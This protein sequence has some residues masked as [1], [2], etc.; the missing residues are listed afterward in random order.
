MATKVNRDYWS[1]TIYNMNGFPNADDVGYLDGQL[2]DLINNDT[3]DIENND[4]FDLSV[5]PWGL[6]QCSLSSLATPV[7]AK[8]E[9]N[10][11]ILSFQES[12]RRNMPF[13]I[14]RHTGRVKTDDYNVASART[15]NKQRIVGDT[16][17]ST[18]ASYNLRYTNTIDTRNLTSN[19]IVSN[20]KPIVKLQY[21]AVRAWLGSIWYFDTLKYD[22]FSSVGFTTADYFWRIWHT[23]TRPSSA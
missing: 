14:N 21:S 13:F 1:G 22:N 4:E 9:G 10:K 2:A 6:P 18:S 17:K 20:T 11:V 8:D 12:N 16:A 5:C 19:Y 3:W 7:F 15:D 23:I